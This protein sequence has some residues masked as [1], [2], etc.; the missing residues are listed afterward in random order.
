MT[1]SDAYVRHIDDDDDDDDDD[2]S[3]TDD[4]NNDTAGRSDDDYECLTDGKATYINMENRHFMVDK[5]RRS[6]Y[7]EKVL[8]ARETPHALMMVVEKSRNK[9]FCVEKISR[10]LDT[11]RTMI[12]LLTRDAIGK[13]HI[14]WTEKGVCLMLEDARK[15][16]IA[17]Y[18]RR[19][20]IV[21]TLFYIMI[22][23]MACTIMYLTLRRPCM[24]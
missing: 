10:T 13:R 16:M 15:T 8:R 4:K 3:E 11:P 18:Y 2:I 14:L 5:S 21:A 22:L 23:A 17:D 1:R 24:I 12:S 20:R 7:I 6:F 19:S 9:P